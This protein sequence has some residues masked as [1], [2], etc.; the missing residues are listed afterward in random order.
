MAKDDNAGI[1]RRDL[2]RGLWRKPE[3]PAPPPPPAVRPPGAADKARFDSLCD[4]C[5]D[6]AS[7]CPAGAIYMTGP[8]TE[9]SET[10]PEILAS[11]SPCVMCE[12]LRCIPACPT[13]A[14]LPATPATMRIATIALDSDACWAANG[15][16]PL[17]N[18]CVDHCPLGGKAITWEKGAGPVLHEEACTGCGV[19]VHYCVATPKALTAIAV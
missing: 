17:C 7:A 14:L 16:E 6:C 15:F 19:C 12:G 10:S 5:G 3:P 9:H 1:G 13:G 18:H 8:L 4:G 2:L 11:F